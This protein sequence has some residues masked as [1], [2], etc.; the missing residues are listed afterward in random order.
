MSLCEITWVFDLRERT[1]QKDDQIFWFLPCIRMPECGSKNHE[2]N[3][4]GPGSM[5]HSRSA[6]SVSQRVGPKNLSF[7]DASMVTLMIT[8]M[9]ATA[10]GRYQAF[11]VNEDCVLIAL[12]QR[13]F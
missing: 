13:N 6:E 1:H 10:V 2:T 12:C 3:F 11:L 4:L 7:S 8:R 5:Y 9:R